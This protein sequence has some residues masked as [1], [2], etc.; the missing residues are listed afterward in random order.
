MLKVIVVLLLLSVSM[1]SVS[2]QDVPTT[3]SAAPD[4]TAYQ[5]VEIASGLQNPLYATSAGDGSGRLFVLE[6]PG[7]IRVIQDGQ[8][9]DI[10]FLDLS[11]IVNREVLSSYSERGLLGLTFHPNFA[12]NGLFFVHYSDRDGNTVI[13]R[14][15]V[16]ADDP[17]LGDFNS[18]EIIFTHQ[19]P[20]PNHNGGQIDFGPDGNLY[21]GLGD[22]GAQGD[23]LENGQNPS[24]LLA[25]ILRINV[26]GEAPYS[27]PEDN[28]ATTISAD[29]APEVWAIGLRNPYR[30]S[31]D[32][33][34][35]DLYIAD[36]GQNQW[37]EI[38]FQPADSAG[39]ENYG[40]NIYEAT[41]PYSDQSDAQGMTM[42]VA[43]YDHSQGCSVTGG[44]V[45]RGQ[46]L[47]EL[48]G[49]YFYGD[50]CSGKIWATYRDEANTWQTAEFM[51][52]EFQ[53]SGFG[54]DDQGELYI[55]DYGGRVFQ[56]TA[57]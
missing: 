14:Y 5:L 2:A 22:G 13:A 12:E 1:W 15:S 51:D 36:V 18:A 19:Q 49:A 41:H 37:E 7:V 10:P 35:G 53:I 47:P 52:T 43:E 45:Y 24:T 40:W 42:P 27:I 34:T 9:S 3:L 57:A 16:M 29:F 33:A 55:I 31:F 28:P 50:W 11:S 17:T 25:K 26:D 4:G 38:N 6:Q 54:E 21:I 44:Y 46:A 48:Q 39:G 32:A 30:F 20:F 8:L 56:L 23:P